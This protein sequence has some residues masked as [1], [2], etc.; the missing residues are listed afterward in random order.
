MPLQR[1]RKHEYS[2]AWIAIT[3]VPDLNHHAFTQTDILRTY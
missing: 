3:R 1:R 2:T